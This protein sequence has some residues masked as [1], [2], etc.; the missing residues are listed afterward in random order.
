MCLYRIYRWFESN[1]DYMNIKLKYKIGTNVIVEEKIYYCIGFEYIE[2]RGIR[3]I[4]LNNKG[5]S[6]DWLYLYD[7]EIEMLK[8][9]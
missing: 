5:E 2:S 9:K 7:F 1:R 3:Y 6:I 4:L 8:Y